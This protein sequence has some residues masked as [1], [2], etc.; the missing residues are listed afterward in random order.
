MSDCLF[1]IK[2]NIISAGKASLSI[3]SIQSTHHR[4]LI[5]G[6]MH[7]CIHNSVR[8]CVL[9]SERFVCIHLIIVSTTGGAMG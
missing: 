3:T 8:G 5:L 1:F 2:M 9:Q 6:G 4:H 7:A